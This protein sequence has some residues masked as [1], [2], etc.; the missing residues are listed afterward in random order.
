MNSISVKTTY[1]YVIFIYNNNNNNSMIYFRIKSRRSLYSLL[2]GSIAPDASWRKRGG[3]ER[4]IRPGP[5]R[6]VPPPGWV[7]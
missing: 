4:S 7:V 6:R 3:R 2:I 1:C 5:G